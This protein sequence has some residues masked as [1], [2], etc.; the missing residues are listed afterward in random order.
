VKRKEQRKHIIYLMYHHNIL[1]SYGFNESKHWTKR[2]GKK[3][4]EGERKGRGGRDPRVWSDALL[5]IN[6]LF[7]LSVM[8]SNAVLMRKKKRL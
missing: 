6:L 5:K 7:S 8:M 4:K 3:E 1:G 2:E